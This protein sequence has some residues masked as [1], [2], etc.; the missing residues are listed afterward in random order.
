MT[1]PS[2]VLRAFGLTGPARPLSGG[3]GGTWRCGP[4]VLKPAEGEPETVWR[5]SVLAALPPSAEFRVAQPLRTATGEVVVDGWEATTWLPGEP[6]P[7]RVDD[8]IRAGEAFHAALPGLPRPSFLD[9]RDDPWSWGDRLAFGEPV[10]PGAT[11]PSRLLEPLLAARRPVEADSQVVHG[12]LLGNVLFAEGLP[13]AI[14]DWPAYH[15]PTA[16][17]AA[18]AVADAL[19]WHRAGP[20]VITRWERHFAEWPQMLVRAL[21]YRIATWSAARWEQPPDDAYRPTVDRV[22]SYAGQ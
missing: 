15:R 8:V 2:P 18:V 5:A 12:D 22:L 4:A 7:G 1:V 17:S 16:W 11:A 3:K 13:P 9:D 14:I 6:D 19:V 21:I 10:P 20:G